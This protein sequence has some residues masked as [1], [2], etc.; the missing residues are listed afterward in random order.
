MH[1][2]DKCGL[3]GINALSFRRLAN[4]IPFPLNGEQ[5]GPSSSLGYKV[6]HKSRQTNCP[7]NPQLL[8]RRPS[9]N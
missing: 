4:F 6:Q 9:I 7:N 5:K 8:Y 2:G 3:F 1:H